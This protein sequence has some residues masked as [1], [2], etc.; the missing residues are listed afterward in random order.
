MKKMAA[1]A[2]LVFLTLFTVAYTSNAM[3][4]GND[5]LTKETVQNVLPNGESGKETSEKSISF[6]NYVKLIGLNKKQLIST[7]GQQPTSI[8]E[9]GLQFSE[10]DI[11]VWFKDYGNGPVEQVY[12]DNKDVDFKGVKLGDKISSFKD[13]FGKPIEEHV[14]FAYSNF[15]YNGIVLSV[16]YDPK[17]ETTFAVYILDKNVK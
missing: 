6:T 10:S 7:L 15:K 14:T 13:K 8:D 2:V 3:T 11:R 17:T 9:G 4:K 1:L 5:L 12:I 16:Y